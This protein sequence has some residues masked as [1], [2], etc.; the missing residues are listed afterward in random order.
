V[1]RPDE[2][3]AGPGVRVK[4]LAISTLCL[5]DYARL[6]KSI[7]TKVEDVFSKFAEH[8]HAGVHL[9]K[10]KGA[11]DPRCRT[12][13]IDQNYR[14]IV[15]A[16][17]EGE[18]FLLMRILPHAKADQWI[19]RNVFGVNPA[20]GVLEVQDVIAREEVAAAV[21][22]A[23]LG[24]PVFADR[25]AAD[26]I[27]VGI[28]ESLVPVLLRLTTDAELEG[29]CAV[30]PPGQGDALQML[31]SGYTV[32]E[33]R[34]E[35]M[36][37]AVEGPVK[38][39]DTDTA[40]A[41]PASQG[42]FYVVRDAEDLLDVLNRPFEAWRVFLHPS[43][44][45]IA[46]RAKYSGPARVTGGAGTGKTVVAM[47]RAKALADLDAAN[48]AAGRILFTT[49][50]RNLA[51]TI[52]ENLRN[53]GGPKLLARV[54]VTNVDR[55]AYQIVRDAE[56]AA[57][58]VATDDD[59]ASLLDDV[60]AE[61]GLGF[62]ARFLKQEWQQVILGQGLTSREDYFTASRFGRGV[63]LDRRQRAEV[64]KGIEA[65]VH[66]LLERGKRTHLQLADDAARSLR[67]RGVT[68]Y[69]HV[70]VDEAQDLHPAQW[71][72]LRATVAEGANDIFLVGDSHQRIYENRVTLSAVGVK[73]RGRSYR[74][75]LN[76]RTTEEILRWSLGLLAGQRFDDL[77]GDFDTL[78]GYRSTSHG[79]V[80]V[81]TGYPDSRAEG[82]G[83]VSAVRDWLQRNV[84][85]EAIGV[86]ARTVE[87][88]RSAVESLQSEGIPAR[89]LGRDDD[90]AGTGEVEVATM[91]RMKGLEYRC[92]AVV[93]VSRGT[94]PSP[95]A[96]TAEAEDAV[97]H[98]SDLLRERSLLFVACTRGRDELW[99]SWSG[100]PSGFLQERAQGAR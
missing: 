45:R 80:P 56:G 91:H 54:E 79:P 97:A 76:Y 92:L 87:A 5:P 65:L 48:G 29:I 23:D 39:S 6:D 88:C 28:A 61:L 26:F 17:E 96:V 58:K 46:Y 51:R 22:H 37:N 21:G 99:I 19:E 38:E 93:D 55:L 95:Y 30:L 81:L 49:F 35:V 59:L 85:P 16:P 40:I 90:G 69:P 84:Q 7:R 24:Q 18:T 42:M 9:E 63:R 20:S 68:L 62:S 14:G 53:L 67:L 86:S 44:R 94:V 12:I 57:P 2:R 41:R 75:R 27:A 34:A 15:M 98:A 33:A 78:V 77:D 72:M 66:R 89:L 4:N 83:L 36:A 47:H 52:E 74:L 82:Q 1:G 31:A 8:T 64:W 60:V 70:I 43:Q 100:H 25:T 50:S 13:R 32:G 73:V 11:R 3:V 71:R 10:L